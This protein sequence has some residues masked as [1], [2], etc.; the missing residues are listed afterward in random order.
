MERLRQKNV[1]SLGESTNWK[2]RVMIRERSS[3]GVKCD[4]PEVAFQLKNNYFLIIF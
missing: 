4:D 2:E 1:E 3:S